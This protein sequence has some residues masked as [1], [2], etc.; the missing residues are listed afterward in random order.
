MNYQWKTSSL[1]HKA[2]LVVKYNS[3]Q[4]A[5]STSVK[6]DNIGFGLSNRVRLDVPPS[7][8]IMHIIT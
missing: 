5:Y 6:S 7:Q 4:A 1:V 2:I 3:N 8:V